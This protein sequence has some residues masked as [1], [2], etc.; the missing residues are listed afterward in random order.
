[1][2]STVADSESGT[3]WIEDPAVSVNKGVSAKKRLVQGVAEGLSA[4]LD[5]GS[6]SQGWY[7]G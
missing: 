3:A 4:E 6:S 7:L 5:S 2:Q 1:M